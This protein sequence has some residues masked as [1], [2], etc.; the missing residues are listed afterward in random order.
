MR[1]VDHI[2]LNFNNMFT[3]AV[4]LAIDK[5]FNKTWHSGQLYK[6]L[7]LL[8]SL[9][10]IIASFLN[11]RK[12]KVLIEG[13]FSTPRAIAAAMAQGSILSP[14]LYSLYLN[15]APVAPGIHLALFMDDTRICT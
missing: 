3:A 13:E 7:E 4:F 9:I 8:K 12:F 15:N 10:R 5:S 1:L 6:L 2:T 14:V 11:N